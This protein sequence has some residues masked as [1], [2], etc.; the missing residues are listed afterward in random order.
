MHDQHVISSLSPSPRAASSPQTV[1]LAPLHEAYEMEAMELQHI[2]R[3]ADSTALF[4]M[5]PLDC[6]SSS[7]PFAIYRSIS[8]VRDAG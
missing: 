1:P 4:V 3:G 5:L 8:D 6:V 2:Q 7:P